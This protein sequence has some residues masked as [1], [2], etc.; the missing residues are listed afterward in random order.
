MSHVMESDSRTESGSTEYNSDDKSS[1]GSSE[2]HSGQEPESERKQIILV[3]RDEEFTFLNI[4]FPMPHQFPHLYIQL[5]GLMTHVD[6]LVPKLYKWITSIAGDPEHALGYIIHH[7]NID[8]VSKG[9][10]TYPNY[11]FKQ[12]YYST[13]IDT[14][15]FKTLQRYY[16]ATRKQLEDALVQE[17]LDFQ[18][19][20]DTQHTY[21]SLPLELLDCF[22]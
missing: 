19:R 12:V 13:Y 22:L 14:S 2:Y 18:A 5:N 4:Q 17:R 15:R 9:L 6:T 16:I 20:Y 1:Q 8:R 7:F 21:K 10:H 3:N 11:T